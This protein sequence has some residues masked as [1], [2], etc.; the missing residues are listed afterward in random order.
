MGFLLAFACLGFIQLVVKGLKLY[1]ISFIVRA[2]LFGVAPI[3]IVFL[4]FEKTKPLFSGWVNILVNTSLQP[5]LYFTF[6][7]FFLVMMMGAARDM[8]GA[9]DLCWAQTKFVDGTSNTAAFWKFKQFGETFPRATESN[10]RGP[11][12]CA[13]NGQ[14]CTEFPINIVD[15]LAFVI[16]VYVAMQFAQVVEA[17]AHE[18]SNA[19]IHMSTDAK[20][21][22]KTETRS[23]GGSNN[24][25]TGRAPPS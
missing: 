20:R 12:E 25:N 23:G 11:L 1:A 7:S 15:I 8:L 19:A 24:V 6:I 21:D 13:I 18:L 22:F 16:L 5:I 10:W 9:N 2:L 14:Q 17:I 4:L 3:F